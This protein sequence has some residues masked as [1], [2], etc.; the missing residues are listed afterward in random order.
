MMP[1]ASLGCDHAVNSSHIAQLAG[2]VA[3]LPVRPTCPVRQPGFRKA[4]ASCHVVYMCL[5][6]APDEKT[7]FKHH[8]QLTKHRGTT[9]KHPLKR[10]L[11]FVVFLTSNNLSWGLQ[12]K[13]S[14][15]KS[16]RALS[17]LICST[18]HAQSYAHFLDHA[19]G[20]T[21]I[22]AER[23]EPTTMAQLHQRRS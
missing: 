20:S 8:F 18:F 12:D 7:L 13:Q 3:S 1:S 4:N 2:T 14:V 5:Q 16:R 9:R 6:L 17:V 11:Q 10:L 15:L 19:W 23:S 21:G 22:E